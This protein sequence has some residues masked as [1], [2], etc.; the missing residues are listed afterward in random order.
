MSRAHLRGPFDLEDEVIDD[1]VAPR[2]PGVFL[3]GGSGVFTL[4]DAW[5]G[6]SDT[7]VNNQLHVY[8]DSY[9]Y[10]S[11]QYSSSALEAFEM[12]CGI[13]HDVH[14]HDNALHPLRPRGTDWK[15]PRCHLLG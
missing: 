3:L 1:K 13:F 8:V 15:C 12:E 2:R 4:Q 9:R 10:F 11:F 7:D 5:V 14:P 6:R